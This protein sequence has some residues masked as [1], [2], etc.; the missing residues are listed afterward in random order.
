MTCGGSKALVV[1]NRKDLGTKLLVVCP[2]LL[3]FSSQLLEV[4]LKLLI[5][6]EELLGVCHGEKRKKRREKRKRI[7]ERDVT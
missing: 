4:G 6:L 3:H 5:E 2:E 7:R 1:P